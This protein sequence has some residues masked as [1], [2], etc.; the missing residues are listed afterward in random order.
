MA[1][2]WL[3]PDSHVVETPY[4]YPPGADRWRPLDLA[5]LHWTASPA[6]DYSVRD[7]ADEARV[8]RWLSGQRGKSSTHLVI[9]RDGT[10]LQAAP[11]EART[12]HAGK[13]SWDGSARVN[14]RS[15]GID[16]ECVGPVRMTGAGLRDYYGG[17]Y[18]GPAPVD[19]HEPVTPAQLAALLDLARRIVAVVPTLADPSR[20]VGHCD[21]SP[22][23]KSDPGP[24]FPW[25]ALRAEIARAA[26]DLT[27]APP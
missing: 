10:V 4:A 15:V 21:V 16:V 26:V 14:E 27:C 5:V 6:R 3:V 18:L 11:L 23:R 25:V 12:W 13:A 22:G 17:R 2:T 20:W 8:R 19:G 1:P 9:L 24:A 7:G